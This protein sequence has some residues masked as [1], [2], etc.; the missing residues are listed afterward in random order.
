MSHSITLSN[1]TISAAG[2]NDFYIAHCQSKI[3]NVSASDAGLT[4]HFDNDEQGKLFSWFWVRDHG[5]DANSLDQQTLQRL[6]DTF[7]TPED[8]A[9]T[10]VKID[11]D[12]QLLELHWSTGE[13]SII[14]A[15]FFA[16]VMGVAPA[17][18]DLS[19]INP[20]VLWDKT[21]PLDSLPTVDFKSVMQ[22]DSGLQT[23]LENIHTYG[24]SVVT[25]V[26]SNKQDTDLLANRVGLVQET[27]FGK[28][29]E[30][31]SEVIDHGDSAYSTSYLEPHTD[32]TYY[33]DAAGLQMFNCLQF[34]GRGGGSTQ[35]DGF[36]IAE[37]IRQGDPEAYK[38]LTQVPVIGHYI[39]PGVHVR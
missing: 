22:G 39:E 14:S 25:D 20:R 30:L 11:T 2:F 33:H 5:I 21:S 1:E 19:P 18:H 29:W 27:L 26:P 10:D 34:D 36:A 15:Y 7:T 9:C 28:M 6:T 24:F 32:G 37:Q 16:S 8:I 35:V 3:T 17:R 31:S 13:T 38:T 4:V 12:S 23:W